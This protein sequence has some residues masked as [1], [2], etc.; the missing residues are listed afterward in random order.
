MKKLAIILT[1]CGLAF[2]LNAC[3]NSG[4]QPHPLDTERIVC[5]S[6][7]LTEMIFALGAQDKLVGT[8]LSS[9]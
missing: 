7:Q 8:D 1:A 6:K 2:G 5:V 3:K 4:R 9:T